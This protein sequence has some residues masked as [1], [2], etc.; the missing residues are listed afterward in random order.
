MRQ[1]AAEVG[2]HLI[3]SLERLAATAAGQLIGSVRGS[4]L[5]L[6]IEFVKDRTSL[7]PATAE[8]S[9]LCSRLKD[10]HLILTSI[11]GPHDNVLVVKPPLC[12]SKA[13]CT[14]LVDALAEEL[15]KLETID[16][17]TV[18]HTPT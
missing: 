16:L 5:F 13:D 9:Y 10:A 4:G 3:A 18:T 12:F 17:A 8:T 11:D 2:S 15:Q 1:H 7:E 14:A 6:G